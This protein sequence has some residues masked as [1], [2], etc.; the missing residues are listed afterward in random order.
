[1]ITDPSRVPL[2]ARA[3]I[4]NGRFGALVSAD[5]TIDWYCPGGIGSAPVLWRLLD[6]AGG[7]IRV[8][9]ERDGPSAPRRL[10]PGNLRYRSG[11]NVA[12]NILE[13][14][15]GRRVSVVDFLP[16]PGSGL[17]VGGRIVRVVR[18]LSGPVDV[19][20]EVYPAGPFAGARDVMGT[21]DGVVV[22]D[23]AVQVGFPLLAEPLGRDVQRWRAVKRL[24]EGEGFAVTAGPRSGSEAPLTLDAALRLAHE[25]ETA[26]RSWLSVLAYTGV[27]RAAVERSLLAVRC[28]TGPAGAPVAA[29]TTSLPRRPGS[30]RN[31][32]GRWVRWQDASSA[33]AT[34]AAA[35]FAEDAEAAEAW[36]RR[37][38]TDAPLPW[39]AWLDADGQPPPGSEELPLQGWRMSQPVVAGVPLDLED[40][41]CYGA[42]AGVIGA[43]M[44]G[45]GGRPGD[46]GPLSAS[47]PALCGATDWLADHWSD[48][49]AGVWLSQGPPA[50]LV[51][52]GLQAWL[53]FDRMA[54]HARQ[55]NPLDLSAAVWQQEAR[56]AMSWIEDSG[57]AA[58]GG[59]RRDGAQSAGDE[60]DAALLRAAWT[61][62]WPPRHHVVEATVD[63]V[64]ERLSAGGLLYRYPEKV[65][66]GHAGPD[67]PDLLATLWAARALAEMERW[68]EAH[69]RMEA[70][71]GLAGPT[72][73]LSEAAD[74]VA[75]ELT[76]NLPS[77]SVHLA[78]VDAAL[79]LERGPA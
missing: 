43:S 3:W 60:P 41:D 9:P 65:D 55:A 68:D 15:G 50:R 54:R 4:G 2:G 52:T 64:L 66:D 61:G 78:L 49:D 75:A 71:L 35:G 51:S 19:E 13:G 10:P 47:W 31:S 56:A 18:A 57:F 17:E 36:L 58:D 24:E 79:A 25:T 44:R 6:P 70:V 62:P 48:P 32:D 1:M 21:P 42:V 34:L 29:G 7:A 12:E 20:V 16:W 46:P 69:E 23:L 53:A 37:S 26:W 72:G 8:G 39:P 77:T 22:D 74:P 45:P 59:L 73:I 76:G 5:A 14:P 33:V 30:E 38:V 11:T 40:I 27:Y 67:N 63:R 28:L